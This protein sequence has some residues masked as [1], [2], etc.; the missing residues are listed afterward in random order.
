[1]ADHHY[2]PAIRQSAGSSSIVA[3]PVAGSWLSV[4]RKA[5]Q[6]LSEGLEVSETA[7]KRAATSLPTS[8]P[9]VWARPLLFYSALRKGSEH[10]LREALQEEWRGLLSLIALSK[11]Y[12]RCSLRLE[13][14]TLEGRG[15]R[16]TSALS[17]L[18]PSA[19]MLEK[20]RAYQWSDVLLLRVNDVTVGALSP[21]TLVYT[22]VRRLSPDIPLVHA[23]TGR[24]RPPDDPTELRYVALWVARLEAE[25]RKLLW[26]DTTDNPDHVVVNNLFGLLNEWLASLR[27]TLGLET[28]EALQAEETQ[29]SVGDEQSLTGSWAKLDRYLVYRQLLRPIEITREATSDV[30]LDRE[31]GTNP[32]V[33]VTRELLSRDVT[34]WD[35]I[36][37]RQLPGAVD[38]P[39]SA[40]LRFFNTDN[41]TRI[42]KHPMSAGAAWVRPDKY[43]L[44]DTL[45]ASRVDAPLIADS[46]VTRLHADRRFIYPF[47]PEILQFFSPREI[48]STLRPRFVPVEG[49]VRFTFTLPL[50]SSVF[51]TIDISKDYRGTARTGEG[52]IR[53]TEPGPLYVFPRY[54]SRHWRRYYVFAGKNDDIGVEPVTEPG[55]AVRVERRK[56]ADGEIYQLTGDAAFPEALSARTKDTGHAGLVLLDRPS[57][58]KGLSG[59][60]PMMIGVDYGTSNTNVYVLRPDENEPK[61]WE[62]DLQRHMQA[63]FEGGRSRES[64]QAYLPLSR[65]EFPIPTTLRVFDAA[66]VDHMFLDYFVYFSDEIRLPENVYSDLKWQEIEKT[67]QFIKSLLFLLLL[68]VVEIGAKKFKILFSYPKAFSDLQQNQLKGMWEKAV[69]ELTHGEDRALNVADG[70]DQ[71]SLKPN[72][73]KLEHTVEAVAAGEFFASRTREG[74][75]EIVTIENPLNRASIKT[76][77]VCIDVGGGTTDICIWQGGQRV[78]DASVLLAGRQIGS[79]LRA[80]GTV[81]ELLFER[82]NALALKEVEA[83]PL[84]FAARL[85]QILRRYEAQ[86]MNN[87]ITHG[88]HAEIERLRRLLAV[89]FGS[90]AFYT[91]TLLAAANQLPN[92]DGAIAREVQENGVKLHWGGN[93]AKMLRWIDY[94]HFTDDGV[95]SRMLRAVLRNSLAD[96]TIDSSASNVGNKESPKHKSEV[97]AGLIVWNNVREDKPAGRGS[98]V[99]SAAVDD[100][101]TP[102]AGARAMSIGQGTSS[103]VMGDVVDT[104]QGLLPFDRPISISQLF[105]A[106]GVTSVKGITMERMTRFLEVINHIGLKTGVID[107]GKQVE[108]GEQFRIHIRQQIRGQ[109]LSMAGVA[110]ASR[111][112]EP[113]FIAEI[114]SLLEVL[115]HN[116]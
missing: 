93:A 91:G 70:L 115:S 32:V 100:D 78:L 94:G 35:D 20:G 24:L 82:Q 18:C 79:W 63:V 21:L 85:N 26:V 52:T 114:K 28:R 90:I 37:A 59:D 84:M 96:A 103:I 31:R 16:F 41:G 57:E 27:R 17:N 76:L 110:A 56:R 102:N 60:S 97:A 53:R 6:T 72:R 80:N 108:L 109:F 30:L 43:F 15:D 36:K 39:D 98:S 99:P 10:P 45:I 22:G 8:L 7:R 73:D 40:L 75:R 64:F 33:V 44:S 89:E 51:K 13:P 66:V 77:A 112:V 88:T 111:V 9:D 25:L 4:E 62:V 113:V 105:P 38:D 46:G 67:K 104:D 87:L 61:V 11:Y 95:A 14:L 58:Q 3:P 116:N 86:I 23:E 42:D 81:R 29:I 55:A 54:M 69:D 106:D 2:L 74:K 1:M 71:D 50:K 107:E 101:L 48:A 19:V 83:K 34:L 68:D 47:R 49:G 12:K 65:I 92:V 5:I